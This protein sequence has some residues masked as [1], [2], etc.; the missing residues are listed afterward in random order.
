[1]ANDRICGRTDIS[2]GIDFSFSAANSSIA[3]GKQLFMGRWYASDECVVLLGGICQYTFFGA[4]LAV[5]LYSAIQS[6]RIG[7]FRSGVFIVAMEQGK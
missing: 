5:T 1:M 4:G 6:F 3:T 2:N 7:K